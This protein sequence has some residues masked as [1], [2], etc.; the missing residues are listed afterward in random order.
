M[1]LRSDRPLGSAYLEWAKL[2]PQP[3]FSLAVSG[4]PNQ[5]MSALPVRWDALELSGP[6]GYGWAPLVEALA[7]R[8]GVAPERLV[9]ATGTSMA[10]YVAMAAVV[11][12]GDEV[13]IERPAYEPL[14]ALARYLGATVTRFDRREADGFAV[15]PA[16][17]AAALTARTRLIVLTNLHNPTGTLT[18][19]ATLAAVGARAAAVGARVLVDEVY[20]D[21][22]FTRAPGLGSAIHLGP[23]FVVTTSLTKVYGLGGLRCGWVLADPELARRMWRIAD[24]HDNNA[25]FVSQQLSVIA[26]ATLAALGERARTLL[27]AN[28]ALVDAFLDDR[29]DLEAVRPAHGTIVFPRLRDGGDAAALCAR[30]RERFET[31][32]VPGRF[33]ERP[34]HFRLG[35]GGA[36]ADLRE[37]LTRLGAAL[38]ER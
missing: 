32:V 12:P 21:A 34:S 26:F 19:G 4:M 31:V 18:D 15:S 1:I 36:T 27:D 24:L 10:N 29:P 28:R 25:P 23:S 17:V 14:V 11:E 5:P 35:L 3:A 38:D 30:L 9:T 37:G 2:T 16:A 6:G 33:F 8:A 20:L 7:A 13:L 22:V